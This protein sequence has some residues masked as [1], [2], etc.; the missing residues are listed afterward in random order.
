MHTLT[1]ELLTAEEFTLFGDVIDRRIVSSYPINGGRT[2][3]YDDL[4]VVDL[5]G[6]NARP[7]ISLF[8]SEPVEIPLNIDTLERHPLGSQAFMPLHEERF[9]I[10]VAPAGD[11]IDPST[12]RAFLTDGRQGVNYRAGTWH[13]VHS[14]LDRKG[15][16]LVI[17]RAG[18]GENCDEW[19]IS[20][21]IVL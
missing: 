6:E 10:V 9:L 21:S 18:A 11:A 5:L 15:E 19:Q 1:L 7:R 17:D 2:Q 8:V 14:V 4:A 3:R 20:L 13:A 16:F 12:V